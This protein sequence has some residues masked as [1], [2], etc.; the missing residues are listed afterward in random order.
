MSWH[1]IVLLNGLYDHTDDRVCTRRT[2]FGVWRIWL[3]L[4]WGL[5]C[6]GLCPGLYW[7]WWLWWLL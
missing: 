7:L 2:M 5:I 3:I 1:N 6:V 4:V